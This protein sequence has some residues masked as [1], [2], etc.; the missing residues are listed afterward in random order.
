MGQEQGG[1]GGRERGGFWG[2]S[3]VVLGKELS[4][5]GG[6]TGCVWGE[7]EVVLGARTGWFWSK[8]RRGFGGAQHSGFG[9]KSTVVSGGKSP[10]F[11]CSTAG[12]GASRTGRRCWRSCGSRC[13]WG[14]MGREQPQISLWESLETP[15]G[16]W[17]P[18]LKGAGGR[19]GKA[20]A[21]EL[22]E[23]QLGSHILSPGAGMW[24]ALAAVGNR[25]GVVTSPW[26]HGPLE[27]S[28]IFLL[29]FLSHLVFPWH[30]ESV[31]ASSLRV[32]K[33][34]LGWRK[35]QEEL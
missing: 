33:A 31:A 20:G 29:W 18:L 19:A 10:N 2:D 3:E 22:R 17:G 30:K 14:E 1:F 13:L 25:E 26:D 6:R 21:V 27:E 24:P 16:G 7:N 32:S 8:E 23:F 28:Q 9:G 15:Q 12:L 11:S 35:G 34:K 5:L 4:G